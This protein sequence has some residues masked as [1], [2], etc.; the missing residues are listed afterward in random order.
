MNEKEFNLLEEPWILVI[1]DG[2]TDE[3]SLIDLFRY[4]HKYQKLAGEL[5]TQDIAVM[6]LLLAVLHAT[7]GRY[8]CE[9]VYKPVSKTSGANPMDAIDRW[10]S[11][12]DRK[13]FPYT[14]IEKYLSEYED[15]F[16]LFHPQYPFYQVAA[17]AKKN[18]NE[19]FGPFDISKMNSV[20][21]EGDNKTRLFPQLTGE[22]K[23]RL[24]YPEAARH[25]LHCNAFAET[26]GKLEAKNKQKNAATLGVGWL[27]KLG[28]VMALGDNVFETLMLNM[29]MLPNG[30]ICGDEKP[31]WE[32]DAVNE[33]ERV[34][35]LMPDNPSELLTI[36]SRRILL[37]RDD[38]FVTRYRFVSGDFFIKDNTMLNE[39]MTVWKN[40][41]KKE[42]KPPVYEPKRHDAA[43]KMWRD[44]VFYTSINSKSPGIMEWLVL[45][46]SKSV[47]KE[48]HF[49][50][51]TVSV[52]YGT[53][54][55]MVNDVFSDSLSFNI[56][57][58]SELGKD[59]IIRIIGEIKTTEDL[60][61]QLW[62]FA[63]NLTIAEGGSDGAERGNAAREQ[64][65]YQLDKPFRIWLEG[66]D[67][68]EIERDSICDVWFAE[69]QCIVRNIGK[70]LIKQ[71]SKNSY[72]G[73][74]IVNN[75]TNMKNRYA[76]P[77]L[78][79]TFLWKTSS[80]DALNYTN[81]KEAGA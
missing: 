59:W 65:Y 61:K 79:N 18:E 66:I 51:M 15:R 27:G 73:R 77:E 49:R 21:L 48:K 5:P 39:Q 72:I 60:V 29:V 16:W 81:R 34:E 33:N 64:A 10:K 68:E 11:L 31:I 9:G 71:C 1:N 25:L 50:F 69:A 22:P 3:V 40:V 2:T 62:F 47:L 52:A 70:E 55:A 35:I 54:Q 43:K 23:N 12:W 56:D 4:A 7:F 76:A 14:V 80:R 75:K 6:R 38:G 17:L 58:L 24:T 41:E 44:F 63:N 8:D 37:E 78:F 32:T 46:R 74:E 36:Q 28:L 20:L 67:P 57:L 19:I 53:M 42:N 13:E 26:F 45:L 30:R